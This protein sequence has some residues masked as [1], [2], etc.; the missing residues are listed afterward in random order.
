[1]P[2]HVVRTSLRT[3]RASYGLLLIAWAAAACGSSQP[4]ATEPTVS[5]TL[6]SGQDQEGTVGMPLT[7]PIVA[8]LSS[9][10]GYPV[11]GRLVSFTLTGSEGTIASASG[12]GSASGM[13]ATFSVPTD[14]QG[15][16]AARF[17][18][19]PMSGVQSIS[20]HTSYPVKGDSLLQI[21]ALADP[22]KV[23]RVVKSG[24]GQVGPAGQP[25][26]LD[27]AVVV[28]D[29]YGNS[30][31]GVQVVWTVLAGGGSLSAD[32]VLTDDAGGAATQWTLGTSSPLQQVVAQ[33][34]EAGRLTFSA[35]AQ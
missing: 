28:S 23:A 17:T 9:D 21:D 8:Q 20:V 16:A 24:D 1:M 19:G 22:G 31:V 5:L 29:R 15:H 14:D 10:A 18:L 6:V 34:G 32:T 13:G 35:T 30:L 7:E 25:L 4:T 33:I 27:V 12:G 26:P 2:S 11:T 3:A